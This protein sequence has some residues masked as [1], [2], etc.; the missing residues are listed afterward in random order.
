MT[1]R[2]DRERGTT[3][4][5]MDGAPGLDLL[6]EPCEVPD[7]ASPEAVDR[8]LHV[9]DEEPLRS[10][11]EVEECDLGGVGVLKLVH[12]QVAQ[13]GPVERGYVGM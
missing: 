6:V 4:S 3:G 8:L 7:V 1:R 12:H 9:A 13:A 11:Q 10:F 5:G 2:A